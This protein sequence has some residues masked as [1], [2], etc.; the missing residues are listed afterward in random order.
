MSWIEIPIL[1][2][3]PVKRTCNW[4]PHVDRKIVRTCVYTDKSGPVKFTK[5]LVKNRQPTRLANVTRLA[6]KRYCKLYCVT[7]TFTIKPVSVY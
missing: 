3:F 7:V 5:I 1:R 4:F 6:S 2:K